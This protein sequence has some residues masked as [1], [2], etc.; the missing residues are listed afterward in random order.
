MNDGILVYP[1]IFHKGYRLRG[2]NKITHEPHT[3]HKEGK[4]YKAPIYIEVQE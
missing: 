2:S 3:W 1:Q 4:E